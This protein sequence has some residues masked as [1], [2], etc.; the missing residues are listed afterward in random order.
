MIKQ[1]NS[2]LRPLDN[3]ESLPVTKAIIRY[4]KGLMTWSSL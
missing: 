4:Y 2:Q 3:Y 1:M